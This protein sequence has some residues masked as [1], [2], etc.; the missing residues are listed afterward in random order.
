MKVKDII[1]MADGWVSNL[2]TTSEKVDVINQVEQG[3]Y[4]DG[5]DRQISD[6]IDTVSEQDAYSLTGK[7][8][9]VDDIIK[10]TVNGNRYEK[11]TLK[12]NLLYTFYQ[13]DNTLVLN[14]KP[15]NSETGGITVIYR[16]YPVEKTAITI[17]TDDLDIVSEFGER[18]VDL[19]LYALLNK[20]SIKNQEF[21]LANNYAIL[22]NDKVS[23]L[24]G[25]VM[26]NKPNTTAMLRKHPSYWR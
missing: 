9:R 13:V 22:Y 14:P 6:S 23:E 24:H 2:L 3:F 5:Y 18:F 25:Y 19:Y 26:R 12:V 7:A 8:Y 10:L 21:D 4:T 17:T 11:M 15:S 20:Y 16:H 1:D